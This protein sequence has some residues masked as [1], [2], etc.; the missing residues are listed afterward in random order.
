MK[1][2][3]LKIIDEIEKLDLRIIKIGWIYSDLNIKAPKETISIMSVF[4]HD[5][6]IS[7]LIKNLQQ[8]FKNKTIL[9]TGGTGSFG[10]NFVK[11]ILLKSK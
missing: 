4:K 8:M 5:E 11:H 10:T 9:V 2:K 6:K 3:N 7:K 1:N